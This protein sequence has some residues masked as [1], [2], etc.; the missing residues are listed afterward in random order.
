[1]EPETE[2]SIFNLVFRLK[3]EKIFASIE[4]KISSSKENW[5]NIARSIVG[6]IVKKVFQQRAL[7]ECLK[8]AERE[9]CGEWD[10]HLSLP[11]KICLGYARREF[12]SLPGHARAQR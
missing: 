10:P 5:D 12:E 6:E 3:S 11:V 9:W 4:E 8:R 2:K 7:K 1:M